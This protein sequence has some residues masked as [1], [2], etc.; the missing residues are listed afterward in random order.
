[1]SG[2]TEG[3]IWMSKIPQRVTSFKEY[4]ISILSVQD[5]F[6]T[7][8]SQVEI[9][10]QVCDYVELLKPYYCD[11][12]ERVFLARSAL[13]YPV[14]NGYKDDY[15]AES[16]NNRLLGELVDDIKK[17]YF[18]KDEEINVTLLRYMFQKK[19]KTNIHHLLATG[20]LYGQISKSTLILLFRRRKP[21]KELPIRLTSH[22]KIKI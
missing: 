8:T 21:M 19:K 10:N 7:Y 11:I 13:R 14:N 12:C 20:N 1:M 9:T 15:K 22:T 16:E 18:D 2:R 3:A 17:S 4:H 6:H 5:K